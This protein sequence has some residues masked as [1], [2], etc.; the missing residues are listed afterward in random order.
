MTV[1]LGTKNELWDLEPP[2]FLPRSRLFH[3]LPIGVGTPYVESHAL[4]M[5][6]V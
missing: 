2:S 1:N 4:A 3:L 5:F 6:L